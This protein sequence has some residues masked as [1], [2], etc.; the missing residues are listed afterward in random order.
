MA[1]EKLYQDP[2]I[3]K[4]IDAIKSVCGGFCKV[5]Y[6]EDPIRVPATNLP[7]LI[8]SSD[9]T[10]IAQSTN[11]EDEHAM[12]FILTVV[13]DIR[14]DIQDDKMV[15]GSKRRLKDIVEGR[16]TNY[17]LKTNSLLHILRNNVN[18]DVAN[19]LRTSLTT[20]TRIDYGITVDK[21]QPDAWGIEAQIEFVAEFIQLRN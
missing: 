1:Q 9:E 4:Y 12:A 11:A 6:I 19:N 14:Q 13:T 7:C 3:T 10:R 18:I 8:I 17:K 16:D 15:S 5:Y 21:R 20:I 2:V